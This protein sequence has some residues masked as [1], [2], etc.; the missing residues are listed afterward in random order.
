MILFLVEQREHDIAL[1]QI[2]QRF[3]DCRLTLGLSKCQLNAKSVKFFGI[4]FSA[5]GISPDPGKV[6]ALQAVPPLTNNAE[7][8][9]FLGMTSFS[10]TFIPD[11]AVIIPLRKLTCKD[12][13]FAWMKECQDAFQHLKD[14]L[15]QQTIMAYFDPN[16]DTEL[17]VDGSKKDGVASILA[18]K[19]KNRSETNYKSI[20][21]DNRATTATEKRYSQI[22]REFGTFVWDIEKLHIYMDYQIT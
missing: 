11:Y 20:R 15:T 3:Q 13:P 4:I 16:K 18:Q 5:E 8:R 17:I 10:S 12:V 21:Y 22:E 6:E 9:S 19:K 2:L 1:I 14:V 7:V